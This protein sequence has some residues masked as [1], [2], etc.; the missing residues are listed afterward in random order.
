M[1][2]FD[3][4][5]AHGG[6]TSCSPLDTACIAANQAAVDAFSALQAAHNGCVPPTSGPAYRSTIPVAA[7]PSPASYRWSPVLSFQTK[8]P[9]TPSVGDPWTISVSGAPANTAVMVTGGQ[10]G[11]NTTTAIGTTDGAGNFSVS[12]TFTGDQV[13]QWAENWVVAGVPVQGGNFAFTV[14]PTTS[15]AA[16]AAAA[17]APPPAAT[18]GTPAPP[19]PSSSSGSSIAAGAVDL[20]GMPSW[21]WLAGGAAVL[22]LFMMGGKR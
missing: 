19:A 7:A 5:T 17:G 10:G 4:F 20:S 22:L 8:N 6:S 2:E 15:P 21:V 18:Q 3:Y 11:A 14:I 1:S 13:G 12:G 16:A 9:R